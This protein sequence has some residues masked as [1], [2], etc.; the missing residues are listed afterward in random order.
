MAIF[1]NTFGSF[2]GSVDTLNFKKVNGQMVVS[3][4]ITDTTNRRTEAQMRVRTRWLNVSHIYRL[5]KPTLKEG[6]EELPEKL[7]EF[8]YFMK[9]NLS[10]SEVYLSKSFRSP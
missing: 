3:K 8:N 7:S 6:I 2:K 1:K 4:K 5:I 10:T 9:K